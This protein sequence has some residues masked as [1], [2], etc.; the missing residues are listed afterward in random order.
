[1]E[2]LRDVHADVDEVDADPDRPVRE[3][4]AGLEP[5]GGEAAGGEGGVEEGEGG[6]GVAVQEG[7]EQERGHRRPGGER[8]PLAAR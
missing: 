7:A 1:V 8:E 4:F 6:V 5:L 2:A 3:A